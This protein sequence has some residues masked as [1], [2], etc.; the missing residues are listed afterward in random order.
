MQSVENKPRIFGLDIMRAV[1]IT[2][3]MFSHGYA[4][5]GN[6][7]HFSY[8]RWLI[9]D[10]V[11]LF[12]VLSGFLIGSILIRKIEEG[13][14]TLKNLRNF[15]IQRWLRTLPVYFAVLTFLIGCY[16]VSHKELPPVWYKYYMFLQNFS[17]PHPLFFGEAWSL[18]VEEWFYV[19]VP[20]LLFFVLKLPLKKQWLIFFCLISVLLI[21]TSLRL[22]KVEHRDYFAE[23]NLGDQILK[24]VITRLD[25]IMYGVLGAWVSIYYSKRFY[26]Y[27]L[28]F[29]LFGL[30]L[31]ISCNILYSDFFLTR[32]QYSL[33][34]FAAMCLLPFLNSVKEGK[35]LLFQIV[36]FISIISYSMYLSNHMI[37]QRGMMPFILK[38]LNI[39]PENVFQNMFAWFLFWI[40]TIGSAYTLYRFVEK[41]FMELRKRL[42][43]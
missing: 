10:G 3:V 31:L 43:Q 22:Y 7:V 28:F 20:L 14:F 39:Q 40:L 37:V 30:T 16:Y 1:A 4:Y 25:A 9:L 24:V 36:T 42:K 19:I 2:Y 21:I 27:K 32:I 26:Q 17:S 8:Y 38:W 13:D 18:S 23:G 12:F 41:P 11:G 6:V 15:W 29:F 35:G 5:S 34:P 33:A